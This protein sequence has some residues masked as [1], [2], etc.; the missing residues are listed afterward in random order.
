MFLDRMATHM[1]AFEGDAHVEWF[2]GNFE[3]YEKD[4]LRR[5]GAEAA[6]PHRMTHKRL[7]R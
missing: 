6:A 3:E 1:L 4:K 5:L 7:T 2:E